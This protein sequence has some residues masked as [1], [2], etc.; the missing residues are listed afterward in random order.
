MLIPSL[1]NRNWAF[2]FLSFA[3][4]TELHNNTIHVLFRISL[5]NLLTFSFDDQWCICCTFLK[6]HM[7]PS[8]IIVI[9]S[10]ILQKYSLYSSSVSISSKYSVITL[11]FISLLYH[12]LS[13]FQNLFVCRNINW[14][15][16]KTKIFLNHYTFTFA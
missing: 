1:K 7:F 10:G 13:I 2:M 14:N 6:P 8:I 11:F 12:T 16:K 15:F 5:L 3:T 4:C 9:T